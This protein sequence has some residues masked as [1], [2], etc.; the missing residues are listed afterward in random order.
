M[1]HCHTLIWNT[2]SGSSLIGFT[3][4]GGGDDEDDEDKEDDGDNGDDDDDDEYDEILSCHKS[5]LGIRLT[6]WQKLENLK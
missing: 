3:H 4:W 2:G 5:Y 1:P 6:K